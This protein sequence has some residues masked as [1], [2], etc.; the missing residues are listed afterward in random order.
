[1]Y[2]EFFYPDMLDDSIRYYRDLWFAFFFELIFIG[3]S[4]K[5]M[6]KCVDSGLTLKAPNK[7]FSIRH[8][9]FFIFIFQRK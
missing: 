6:Q 3:I 4:I 7:N 1:M 2:G 5:F 8:F 9:I